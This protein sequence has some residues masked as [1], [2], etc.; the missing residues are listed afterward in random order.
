MKEI[1]TWCQG[2]SAAGN[3]NNNEKY[4]ITMHSKSTATSQDAAL[5]MQQMEFRW[6]KRE[7]G[8]FEVAK[9]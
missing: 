9:R 2:I 8:A 7:K 6:C 5:L 3:N 4:S 1:H